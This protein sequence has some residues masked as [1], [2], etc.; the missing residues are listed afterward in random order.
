M[1]EKLSN[2][3]FFNVVCDTAAVEGLTSGA[4]AVFY[5]H[6]LLFVFKNIFTISFIES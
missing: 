4:T 3:K 5:N 6:P 1:K 2:E